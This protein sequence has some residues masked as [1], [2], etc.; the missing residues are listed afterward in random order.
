[1]RA[2]QCYGELGISE[3]KIDNR[4]EPLAA[5]FVGDEMNDDVE[6]LSN[7]DRETLSYSIPFKLQGPT[8]I[9]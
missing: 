9:D 3:G 6:A 7:S 2:L 1:V 8:P 5:K 4:A